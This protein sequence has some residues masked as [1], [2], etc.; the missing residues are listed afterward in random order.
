MLHKTSELRGYHILATDGEIGHVADFLVDEGGRSLRYLVVDTS[1]WLGGR[2]VLI[3]VTAL[4][5]IDSPS[6]KIHVNLTREAIK[7]RA[8]GPDGGHRSRR[9]LAGPVDHVGA[10]ATFFGCPTVKLDVLMNLGR[11]LRLALRGLVRDKGFAI[12]AVLSIGL[13]VARMRRSFRWS[14]RR[15]F[16][17]F[18]S[19]SRSV[20]SCWTGAAPSSGTAGA[21]TT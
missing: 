18:L 11:D 14:I 17:S 20:W 6:K 15:C 7:K 10:L 13:G 5:R 3:S 4:E 12:T 9:N 1:N 21:A 16:D 2:S 8:V 19:E